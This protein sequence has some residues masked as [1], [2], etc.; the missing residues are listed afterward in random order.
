MGLF[1]RSVWRLVERFLSRAFIIQ[2][3]L[4]EQGA[5]FYTSYW[6]VDTVT[7]RSA[8]PSCQLNLVASKTTDFNEVRRQERVGSN[9]KQKADEDIMCSNGMCTGHL[10]R[11][12]FWIWPKCCLLLVLRVALQSSDVILWIHLTALPVLLF[13]FTHLVIISQL[14]ISYQKFSL[15][16]SFC[17]NTN[18]QPYKIVP[19]S[20]T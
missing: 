16:K 17:E 19:I 2:S 5:N 20:E 7:F 8:F 9:L 4:T 15:C 11:L 10:Y 14:L 18:S 13:A 6:Q 12:S 1:T 3:R